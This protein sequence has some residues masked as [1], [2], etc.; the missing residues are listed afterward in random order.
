MDIL[1]MNKIKIF[2][3]CIFLFIFSISL[4]TN[5]KATTNSFIEITNIEANYKNQ[6][7]KFNVENDISYN[8][9]EYG[10]LLSK[11]NEAL[12]LENDNIYKYKITNEITNNF[13]FSIKIPEY[14]LYQNIYAV[15][16]AIIDDEVIYSNKVSSSY[17][18]LANLDKVI[19]K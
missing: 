13:S 2:I 7:I 6:A 1:K 11:S 19:I 9:S 17:A 12:V 18:R 3:I 5:V 14:A 10:I 15:A 16:Y 8:V 4:K